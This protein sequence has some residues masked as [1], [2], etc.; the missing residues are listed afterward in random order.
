M[1]PGR[2]VDVRVNRV[3]DVLEL[4]V[5]PLPLVILTLKTLDNCADELSGELELG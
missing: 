1:V 3:L 2:V 4:L 5:E